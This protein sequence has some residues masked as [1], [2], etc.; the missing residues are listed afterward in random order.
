[1]VEKGWPHARSMFFAIEVVV[2]EALECAAADEVPDDAADDANPGAKVL[3]VLVKVRDA[4]LELGLH[5][6]SRCSARC[7]RIRHQLELEW[8]AD[9]DFGYGSR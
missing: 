4:I 9:N 2:E 3:G 1:M 7:C 8:Y 5:R 6:R